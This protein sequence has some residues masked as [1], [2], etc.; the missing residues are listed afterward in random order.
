MTLSRPLKWLLGLTVV[1]SVLVAQQDVPEQNPRKTP[2][3]SVASP[4]RSAAPG[5]VTQTVAWPRMPAA[6]AQADS[7]WP[8]MD[9]GARYAWQSPPPATPPKPPRTPPLTQAAAPPPPPPPAAPAVAPVPTAPGFPYKLIG[10]FE[11]QGQK[12]ALLVNSRGTF[13]AIANQVLDRDWRVKAV[14]DGGLEVAWLPN[15]QTLK[16]GY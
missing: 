16:I 11:D 7:P 12:T 3:A 9:E 15:G 13:H 6:S 5:Q 4:A 2:A 10:L 8:A 1:A 14:S